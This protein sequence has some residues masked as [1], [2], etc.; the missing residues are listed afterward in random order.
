MAETLDNILAGKRSSL[1]QTAKFL[2][3]FLGST[4]AGLSGLYLDSKYVLN[5][6]PVAGYA[7][8]F[9]DA[10]LTV[11]AQMASLKYY[12]QPILIGDGA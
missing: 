9:V 7:F 4:A 6:H 12:Y 3:G 2:T 11:G 1:K 10:L 8:C 5:S